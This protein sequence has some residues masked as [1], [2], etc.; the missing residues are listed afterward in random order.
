MEYPELLWFDR[1]FDSSGKPIRNDVRE[2]AKT[3]WPQLAAF[4]RHRLGDRDQEIQEVFE[5][6]VEKVSRF[7][8]RKQSPPQDPSALLVIK[9]RQ[10]L[11]ALWRRLNRVITMGT[12][13]DL[14]PMLAGR[15]SGQEAYRH[16][17]LEELVRHLSK[18][19]RTVLRLRGSGY[20]WSEIAKM[21]QSK[22]STVRNNFWREVRRIQSELSE[23]LEDE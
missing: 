22:S 13:T 20:E 9:F 1:E 6:S 23:I 2:A 3:K 21:R 16:I 8:D 7:L 19:N 11:Y 14:E 17:L 12:S 10:E 5:R 18:E 4:A 15:T